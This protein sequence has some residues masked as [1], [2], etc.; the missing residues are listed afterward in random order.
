M[1]FIALLLWKRNQNSLEVNDS[2][3][4][5]GIEKFTNL[6]VKFTYCWHDS[7]EDNY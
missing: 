1:V 7:N 3:K 2:P 6:M 5:G 4:I